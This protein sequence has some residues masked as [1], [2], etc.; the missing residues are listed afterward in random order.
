M[1]ER[2]ERESVERMK[3]I[4]ERTKEVGKTGERVLP[5]NK[6]TS[7]MKGGGEREEEM[8]SKT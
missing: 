2:R 6:H 4:S 5:F 3:Y 8:K 7:K 1:R